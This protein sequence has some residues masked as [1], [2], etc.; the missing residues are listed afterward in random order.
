MVEFKK[1]GFYHTELSTRHSRQLIERGDP[2]K[3]GAEF[4]AFLANEGFCIPQGH[5]VQKDIDLTDPK[6]VDMHK[7]WLDLYAAIGIK[8]AVL[9]ANGAKDEPYEKQLALRAA[10]V[11]ELEAHVAGT[12]LVVCL[13]NLYSQPMVWTIDG[14]L[15]LINAAGG[16][17]NL[18][19]C[20]DTGHL[21]RV[22][23]HGHCPDTCGDFI[24][25]AGSRLKALHIQD[26]LGGDR[27]DHL[28][29]FTNKGLNWK[30]CMQALR[31]SD[32]SGLFNLEVPGET[33][34]VPLEVRR[35][36][37]EYA[38]KLMNRMLSD[39]FIKA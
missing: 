33:A 26:N 9:H 4:A 12:E 27:D 19:I 3:V 18:G 8:A 30:E 17:D 20:L 35:L 29:P 15:E 38:R 6:D 28:F 31:Q 32:Y 2:E 7:R 24:R 34:G 11:R 10:S 13:E 37:M 14:I 22:Y 21:H 16:G 36:K 25:K 23:C 1:N 39:E 5:L